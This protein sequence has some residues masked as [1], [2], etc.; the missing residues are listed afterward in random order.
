MALDGIASLL[1][2]LF[3]NGRIIDA[4]LVLVAC[5]AAILTWWRLRRG[6]GPALVPLM[7]NLVSGAALMLAVRAALTGADWPAIAACLALSFVAHG[8]EL[9]LRLRAP[10]NRS[11]CGKPA[12]R[13]TGTAPETVAFPNHELI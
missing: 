13:G 9:T 8:A 2:G 1:G 7:C 10:A 12:A 6:Y 5:E 3:A 11:A 4:I